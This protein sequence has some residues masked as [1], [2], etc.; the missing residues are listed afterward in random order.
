MYF[1]ESTRGVFPTQAGWSHGIDE[2]FN[3]GAVGGKAGPMSVKEIAAYLAEEVKL[4]TQ[5]AEVLPTASLVSLGLDSFGFVELGGRIQKQFGVELNAVKL[6]PER[7]LIDV[8]TVIYKL[9]RR[10]EGAVEGDEATGVQG[11]EDGDT[12]AS[13]ST[14]AVVLASRFAATAEAKRPAPSVALPLFNKLKLRPRGGQEK[15]GAHLLFGATGLAG[16]HILRYLIKHGGVRRVFVIVRASDAD[17]AMARL[18]KAMEDL[19]LWKPCF[20]QRIVALPGD[21]ALPRFG[22]TAERYQEL[23]DEVGHIIHAAGARS[24]AVDAQS[25]DCNVAGVTNVVGL[26]REGGAVVH[27][28]SSCWLDLYEAAA[29]GADREELAALPYVDIK[30]RGEAILR[31]ASKQCGVRCNIVRLPL[32]SVNSKGAFAGDLVLL[33][34]LQGMCRTGLCPGTEALFPTM[35]SD[36]AAKY[37][38]QAMKAMPTKGDLAFS[39]AAVMAEDVSMS[40]LCDIVDAVREAPIN[41][42]STVHDY[43]SAIEAIAGRSLQDWLGFV[44]AVERASRTLRGQLRNQ[45]LSTLVARVRVKRSASALPSCFLREWV[46][47]H[48][49]SVT[50]FPAD[51]LLKAADQRVSAQMSEDNADVASERTAPSEESTD[52][53]E[54]SPQQRRQEPQ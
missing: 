53:V 23:V 8:A 7:S 26:A 25:L 31:F 34:M 50:V 24:W 37:F 51:E 9:Q 1:K 47:R 12:L 20:A 49:E 3:I 2:A 19:R 39:S 38:V 10:S 4:I 11:A 40:T 30:R 16:S 27:Y 15:G 35:T 46:M 42:D 13:S 54:A 43:M 18:V 36:A 33:S 52:V 6:S 44:F 28:V 22:L 5:T 21:L 32:F 14:M 29:E 48:P 17:A 41:R 45:G